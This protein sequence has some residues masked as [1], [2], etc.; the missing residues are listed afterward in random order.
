[1]M[2]DVIRQGQLFVEVHTK[3]TG[4]IEAVD[5]VPEELNWSGNQRTPTDLSEEHCGSLR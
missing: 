4:G 3:T 2:I 1:M 5:W